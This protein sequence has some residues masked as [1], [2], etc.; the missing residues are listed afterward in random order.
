MFAVTFDID[1]APDWAIQLCADLCRNANIPATFFITNDSPIISDLK[2][3]PNIEVGIH[4]N[5]FPDSSQG[6]NEKEILENCMDWVPEAK[7]MRIHGLAQSTR[8]L[9][10]VIEETPIETD[11]S[12]LLPFHTQLAA[13]EIFLGDPPR[14]LVRLPYF[15]EDDIVA[16][17]PNWNWSYE[18]VEAGGLK[19]Y[20]F[21]PIHIALNTSDMSRYEAL[22]K[23][24][25]GPLSKASRDEVARFENPNKGARS[26]LEQLLESEPASSFHKIS[27]L[28]SA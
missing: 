14:K 20:D 13:T 16:V 4:P 5:F 11:V 17:W 21:H 10:Q 24:L 19:I 23:D 27:D 8:L 26:F 18:S 2:H 12:L 3:D 6:R 9:T 25:G 1:W 22:K 28:W 15:W 7:S